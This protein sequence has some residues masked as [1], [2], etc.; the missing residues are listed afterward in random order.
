MKTVLITGANRGLGLGFVRHYLAAGDRVLATC[1][2]P[3][4]ARDLTAL[5][6]A[7]PGRLLLDR[8]DMAEP[9]QFAAWARRAQHLVTSLDRVIFNA[10]ICPAE[11]IDDWKAATFQN[12][13]LVNVTAPAL[14]ARAVLPILST[15]ATLAF[16]SSGMGS[17]EHPF[18]PAM[19]F[20]AYAMSKAALNMLAHRLA[21][22]FAGR[23]I[24]VLALNPGWVRTDMGGAE[25]PLSVEEAVTDM[26]ARIA[27]DDSNAR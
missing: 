12:T 10:G 17:L 3:E 27:A 11:D 14:L 26:A 7:H 9:E 1:R 5:A 8:L 25:A 16:I 23:P 13:F 22:R 2:T 4:T 15:P 21:G 20:D 18:N 24:R 6:A 19:P